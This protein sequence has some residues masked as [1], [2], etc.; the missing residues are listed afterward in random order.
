MTRTTALLAGLALLL[1]IVWLALPGTPRVAQGLALAPSASEAL[2]PEPRMAAPRLEG[3]AREMDSPS[4]GPLVSSKTPGALPAL[5]AI[6]SEPEPRDERRPAAAAPIFGRVLRER[7]HQPLADC[8]LRLFQG[9]ELV[10]QVD[11]DVRGEFRFLAKQSGTHLLLE[12][13]EGWA[14]RESEQPLSPA[15][16]EGHVEVRWLVREWPPLAAGSIEGR[17]LSESGPWK[18]VDLPQADAIMLDLVSSEEPRIQRRAQLRLEGSEELGFTLGFRFEQVPD[19]E[20]EL[21][22]SSLDNY[23]WSPSSM[24]LRPPAAAIEFLR[25]DR[26]ETAPL[27]FEVVDAESGQAITDFETRH[28]QMTVSDENGVFLHA[29]PL[30]ADAFPLDRD[31]QWALWDEQ[32]APAF[33]DQRAFELVDGRRVA[34][35][36]LRRGWSTR[37]IVMGN[38]PST[39]PLAGVELRL[40]GLSIGASDARGVLDA[41]LAEPP[42]QL[43][44]RYHDWELA[45][46]PLGPG[47]RAAARSRAYVTPVLIRPGE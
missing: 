9:R 31:F 46:D 34:H 36:E 7:D 18:L 21:T 20:Y 12:P 13:P 39:K 38:S 45:S 30:E 16:A 11:S 24:R 29:G 23:R 41:F 4:S 40:D 32:H 43:E 35:V 3:L 33:G 17:L 27:V 14:A 25:Y 19:T 5:E 42:A 15:Q 8:R 37:F 47:R 26:D 1:A 44:I 10:A 28:I 6:G 22:L 2:R